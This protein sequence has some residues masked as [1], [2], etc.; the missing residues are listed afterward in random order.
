MHLLELKTGTEIDVDG[1]VDAK[2]IR[3]IGKAI[4]MGDGTWRCLAD[5]GGAL[6]R[7]EV[8]ITFQ[9]EKKP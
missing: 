4:L 2:G 5:V 3:F 1:M 9:H 6:C 8:K 7:V